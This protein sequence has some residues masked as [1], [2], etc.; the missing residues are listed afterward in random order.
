MPTLMED[1]TPSWLKPENA[2]VLDPAWVKLLRA[3]ANANPLPKGLQ[4]RLPNPN[5]AA[6]ALHPQDQILALMGA[7]VPSGGPRIEGWHASPHDFDKFDL[8]K[9]GTGEGAQAFGHGAYIA[10]RHGTAKY[11]W[12]NFAGRGGDFSLFNVEGGGKVPAWLRDTIQTDPTVGARTVDNL[13][14]EFQDR[15]PRLKALALHSEEARQSHQTNQI[16]P[17]EALIEGLKNVKAGKAIKPPARMYQVAIHADPEHLLDWDKPLSQQSPHVQEAL[18]PFDLHKT[19]APEWQASYERDIQQKAKT[20]A[21]AAKALTIVREAISGATPLTDASWQQLHDLVP[22]A[23]HHAIG[24]IVEAAKFDPVGKD[25]YRKLHP[26][27]DVSPEFAA[28]LASKTLGDRGI[29][30]IKYLDQI[31]RRQGEGSYNYVVFDEN[32]LEILKKLGL[33]LPAIGAGSQ[34]YGSMYDQSQAVGK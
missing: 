16:E 30:G 24:E 31:S 18:K 25:I 5:P 27:E 15:L 26:D 6:I 20:P 3:I 29:P 8:S 1:P 14:A 10:Q 4:D 17:L 21:D 13:L 22:G 9:V 28:K 2:S 12:E 19:D 32:K 34:T 33:L 11:Y 7:D 23:N